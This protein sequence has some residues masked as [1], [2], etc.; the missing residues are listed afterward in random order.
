LTFNNPLKRSLEKKANDEK[1][2]G[3]ESARLIIKHIFDEI[4]KE[5]AREISNIEQR[6][7]MQAVPQ[8]LEQ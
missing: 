7:L 8:V 2:F 5:D 4:K 6:I 3:I 1:C